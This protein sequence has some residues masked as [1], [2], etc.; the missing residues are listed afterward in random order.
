MLGDIPGDPRGLQLGGDQRAGG[1]R[2]EQ[3]AQAGWILGTRDRRL[4]AREFCARLLDPVG[5]PGERDG[6]GSRSNSVAPSSR[7]GSSGSS[8]VSHSVAARRGPGTVTRSEWRRIRCT[9]RRSW[10][11]ESVTPAASKRGYQ[12]VASLHTQRGALSCSSRPTSACST[13]ASHD[14]SLSTAPSAARKR[15]S[16]RPPA[17]RPSTQRAGPSAAVRGDATGWGGAEVTSPARATGAARPAPHR[18]S[19][20]PRGPGTPRSHRPG[21]RRAAAGRHRAAG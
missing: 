20:H 3:Q 21:P 6:W 11:R 13:V 8:G 5:T 18:A 10:Q 15:T 19:C 2:G 1:L 4:L 14:S 7:R 16:V 9:S 17:A 12:A